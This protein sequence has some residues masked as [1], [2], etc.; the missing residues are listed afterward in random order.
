[1]PNLWKLFIS[2]LLENGVGAIALGFVIDTG[3]GVA[4]CKGISILGRGIGIF[5]DRRLSVPESNF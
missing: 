4:V 5:S 1:M 3:E 2:M